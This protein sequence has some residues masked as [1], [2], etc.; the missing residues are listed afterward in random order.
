V[1]PVIARRGTEHGSG[2]GTQTLGRGTRVRPPALVPPPADP[3]GDTRRHPRSLPHP[4]MRTHQ[5]A[6]PKL[7]PIRS[8]KTACGAGEILLDR[9]TAVRGAL[10]LCEEVVRPQR[11]TKAKEFTRS[12]PFSMCSAPGGLRQD[13]GRAAESPAEARTWGIRDSR[14][15]VLLA[16]YGSRETSNRRETRGAVAG[17]RCGGAGMRA[18]GLRETAGRNATL[19]NEGI[20]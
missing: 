14:T 5:L 6:A 1:K 10:Q 12:L 2:L 9:R 8:F 7:I 3:L 18:A 17:T 20:S 15:R 11:T 4:R 13:P 19:L 16:M